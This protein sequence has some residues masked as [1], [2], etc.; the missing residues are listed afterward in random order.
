MEFKWSFK[1]E[2]NCLHNGLRGFENFEIVHCLDI[3]VNRMSFNAIVLKS[4][5]KMTAI[6][7]TPSLGMFLCLLFASKSVLNYSVSNGSRRN[8]REWRKFV[9]CIFVAIISITLVKYIKILKHQ[10]LKIISY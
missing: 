3:H 7:A 6:P 2:E 9:T 10:P 8:S 1:S 4:L 5:T